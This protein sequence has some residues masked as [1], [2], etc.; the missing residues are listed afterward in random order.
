[1]RRAEV[2]SAETKAKEMLRL[3]GLRWTRPRKELLLAMMRMKRPAT[4]EELATAMGSGA[5]NKV[6]VYRILESLIEKGSARK[7]LLKDGLCHYE[8]CAPADQCHPHFSC[9]GCGDTAC[10][11]GLKPPMPASPYRGFE[12]R[13]QQVQFEGLCPAC[14]R[15]QKGKAERN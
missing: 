7:L 12:I 5:P 11:R 4:Q 6:T 1:M 13:R 3:A 8:L 2:P 15:K 9:L 14:L 10:L